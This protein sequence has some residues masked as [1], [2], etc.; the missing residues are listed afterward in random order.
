[1]AGQPAEVMGSSMTSD[2]IINIIDNVS[3]QYDRAE[4]DSAI[5]TLSPTAIT[6]DTIKPGIQV[7]IILSIKGPLSLRGRNTPYKVTKG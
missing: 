1:M 2:Y 5:P 6:G 7:P 4:V 3:E